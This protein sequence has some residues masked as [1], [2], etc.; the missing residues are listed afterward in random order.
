ME[1]AIL[2]GYPPQ[3]IF[4]AVIFASYIAVVLEARDDL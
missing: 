4:F 2:Y 1:I 3:L